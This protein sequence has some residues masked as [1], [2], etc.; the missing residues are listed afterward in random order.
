M[1]RAQPAVTFTHL[2]SQ[3]SIRRCNELQAYQS[4][5]TARLR[6]IQIAAYVM[7]KSSCDLGTKDGTNRESYSMANTGVKQT[8]SDMGHAAC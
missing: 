2:H 3:L 1:L 8:C 6:M 7:G 5:A 4:N